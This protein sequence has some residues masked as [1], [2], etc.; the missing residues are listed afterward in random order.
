VLALQIFAALLIAGF[1]QVFLMGS[2]FVSP[3]NGAPGVLAFIV[4]MAVL[5]LSSRAATPPSAKERNANG[6]PSAGDA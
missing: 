4:V 3:H 6:P 1:I 5:R 2:G